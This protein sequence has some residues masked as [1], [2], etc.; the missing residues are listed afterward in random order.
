MV[1]L[2]GPKVV[3]FLPL[4]HIVRQRRV[5][6]FNGFLPFV[7]WLLARL[8]GLQCLLVQAVVD[9]LDLVGVVEADLSP[10]VTLRLGLLNE[11]GIH[12]GEFIVFPDGTGG[13]I[14]SG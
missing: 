2:S 6:L 13:Q 11:T 9:F 1:F 7:L 10:L 8:K 4:G 14:V 12:S 3:L 5:L